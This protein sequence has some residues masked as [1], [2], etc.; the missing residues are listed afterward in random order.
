MRPQLPPELP[1]K[2]EICPACSGEGGSSAYLGAYT[3]EDW[4]QMDPEWQDDYQAGK[5]DRPCEC[6]KGT[7]KIKAPD[8]AKI[9]RDPELRALLAD[10]DQEIQD[11]ADERRT[12]MRE[13]GIWDAGY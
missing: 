6:C 12:M 4:D 5:F 13:C 7:G 9:A 3:R 10:Y 1:S 8:R 2:W 11:L